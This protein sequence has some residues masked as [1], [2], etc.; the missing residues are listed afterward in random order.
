M[1]IARI[2]MKTT[3]YILLSVFGILALTWM[4][5]GNDF[6][7]YKY[8]APK[9]EAVRRQVFENTQSYVQGKTDY[10]SQLRLQYEDEPAASPHRLALRKMIITQADT[11]D[12]ALLPSDMQNF[13]ADLKR[14]AR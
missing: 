6:Y 8:F 14:G 5:T 2:P 3:G 12:A 10:I 1:R 11:V 7:L 4:L 13:I 9:R